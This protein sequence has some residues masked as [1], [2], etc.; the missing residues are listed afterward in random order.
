VYDHGVDLRRGVGLALFAGS[1]AVYVWLA[2]PGVYWMDSGELT[3]A[4]ISMGVAHPTGFPLFCLLGR[5]VA[6]VPLGELAFRLN[7]TSALCGAATIYVLYRTGLEWLGRSR[8]ALAGAVTGALLPAVGL[9]FLR[10]STV[11]EVYTPT[12]LVLALALVLCARLLAPRPSVRATLGAGLVLGLALGLHAQLRW[13]V[14]LP[15]LFLLGLRLWRGQRAAA[16]ALAVFVVAGGVLLVMPVRA[17]AERRPA[18]NWGHPAHAS[19]LY[20]QLS[21]GRIRRAFAD[22]MLVRDRQRVVRQARQFADLCVGQLGVLTPILAAVGLWALGRRR[23]GAAALLAWVGALDFVYACWVNP[24]GTEDLQNGVPLHLAL[25]LLAG[26]GVGW[27]GERLPRAGTAA[28][29][30]VG[31][32]ALAPA[33]LSDLPA[34]RCASDGADRLLHAILTQAPPRAAVL[35]VSDDINAGLTLARA[36]GERPDVIGLPQQHL[37]D[38]A[39]VQQVFARAGA[40]RPPSDSAAVIRRLAGRGVVLWE[41]GPDLPPPPLTVLPSAPLPRLGTVPNRDVQPAAQMLAAVRQ[42]CDG[43]EGDAV[44]LRACSSLL[45]GLGNTLWRAGDGVQARAMLEVA[46]ALRPDNAGALTNLGVVVASFGELG[47]AADYEERASALAPDDYAA[48]ANAGR[49][50]LASGDL[51]A[52][53]RYAQRARR[54]R[55]SAAAPLAALAIIAFR[56][57]Q[58]AE[59]QRLVEQARW[60]DPAN[61][62]VRAALAEVTGRR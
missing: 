39:L 30:A 47:R 32:C 1:F 7:L 51:D 3:A 14:V 34:K 9:T 58:R 56:R 15:G 42:A 41:D 52:A 37:W 54:L 59:A 23:P 33:V 49:Y 62:E 55:P 60:L 13:L 19:S 12:A 48:A 20:D 29:V 53:W 17:A 28:A 46:V 38:R 26:A 50:R 57:D 25:G 24:M 11:A 5:A 61:P 21:A 36:I 18:A 4:A 35:A 16:A 22:Q 6:L 31:A 44:G 43:V 27:L 10:Q 40:G 45:T 8:A 2:P